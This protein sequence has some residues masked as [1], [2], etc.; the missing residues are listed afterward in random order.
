MTQN[1]AI[2][3]GSFDPITFGHIDIITRASKIFDQVILAIAHNNTKNSLFSMEK[4]VEMAKNELKNLKN[5]KITDFSGLL[6]DFARRRKSKIIIRGLR[7]I[8]DFEY[9]FQIYNMNSK[10]DPNLQTIFL[11]AS[12]ELQFISS[13]LVKEVVRLKGNVS[14]FVSPEVEEEL[15]KILLQC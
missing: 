7:A 13:K 15:K 8:S 2:Y 9:E 1:I 6:V 5:V 3:P 14:S 11:P 12:T 4:K 10:L